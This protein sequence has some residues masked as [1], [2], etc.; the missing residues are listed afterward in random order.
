MRETKE[1]IRMRKRFFSQASTV[2]IKNYLWLIEYAGLFLVASALLRWTIYKMY[3]MCV[4]KK[5]KDKTFVLCRR[6]ACACTY[7]GGGEADFGSILN[8]YAF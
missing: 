2:L 3:K 6:N 4:Q 7:K 5:K 1:L 8:V